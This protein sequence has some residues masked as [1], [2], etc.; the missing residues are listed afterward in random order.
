MP[1]GLTNAPSTFQ[2]TMNQI[3][4]AFL[5]KFV[6]VFFNDILVYSSSLAD[7]VSHLEQVLSCLHSHCFFIKL[8]KCLFCQETVEYLGHLASAGVVRAD[9]QKITAMVNWPPPTSLKQL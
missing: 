8:S 6:I 2:A 5:C 1:F 4:A 3:F 7:H 9:P